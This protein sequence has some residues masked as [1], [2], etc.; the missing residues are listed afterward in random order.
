MIPP[1]QSAEATQIVDATCR[2]CAQYSS[3]GF[4]HRRCRESKFG[5]SKSLFGCGP[6]KMIILHRRLRGTAESEAVSF[7]Y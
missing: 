5:I 2:K 1:I 7:L 4:D 3:S 6:R